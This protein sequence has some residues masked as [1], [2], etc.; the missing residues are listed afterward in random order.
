MRILSSGVPKN[1]MELLI[2]HRGGLPPDLWGRP[3]TPPLK[4]A[5]YIGELEASW[6][7]LALANLAETGF[8]TPDRRV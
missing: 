5:A 6:E 4:P 8:G 7:I 1:N 3:E 2:E